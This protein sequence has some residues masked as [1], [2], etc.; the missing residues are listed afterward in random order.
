MTKDEK[1][2]QERLKN[3]LNNG[4]YNA[5]IE[6]VRAG[7][8]AQY[9]VN[10][11]R[12][13]TIADEAG[14]VWCFPIRDYTGQE[15]QEM[16]TALDYPAYFRFRGANEEG[17]GQVEYKFPGD[18][19]KK[20]LQAYE[21]KVKSMGFFSR[22]RYKNEVVK[23]CQTEIEKYGIANFR[24]DAELALKIEKSIASTK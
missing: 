12:V 7:C 17:A 21:E 4:E 5:A 19:V 1:L 22:L 20:A 10:N 18:R 3:I 13:A 11:V 9:D 8:P 15:G 23:A 24:K 6:Y 16:R 14:I 2:Y